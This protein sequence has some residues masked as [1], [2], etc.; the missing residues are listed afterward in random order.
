MTDDVIVV[1]GGLAGL[2]A[3]RRL[4]ERGADVTVLERRETVGGRVRSRHRDGFTLDRGFQVL[5]TGYPAVKRELDLDALDL[6]RF[7]PGAIIARPSERS[8]LS[9][10]LRDP[11]AAVESFF[12][13]EIP[14][15]DK[16]R[17]LLL[18]RELRSRDPASIFE[19]RDTDIRTYLQE[20][21]FS[22]AYANN[23]VA[24]FYGGITLDRSLSTSKRVFEYTFAVLSKGHTAV[25]ADGMGAITAQLADRAAAAG[26]TIETDTRVTGVDPTD[27]GTVE[28]TTTEGGR[29]AEAAIVATDPR[30]AAELTGVDGIPIDG[31]ASVTQ[32]YSLPAGAGP[33]TDRRILLNAKGGVASEDDAAAGREIPGV[34]TPNAMVPLTEVAPEYAPGDRELLCATFLG[35]RPVEVGEEELFERAQRTLESWYPERTFGGLEH[36]WTE[37]I[38]FGQFRQPPGIH[39]TLPDVR[40]PDGSVYLA[41]E[42]T[43]WSSIQGAMESGRVATKAVLAD[44]IGSS[45]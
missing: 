32:Y 36:V 9:D 4:A 14:L 45:Q 10:P 23:F 24:P 30:A 6:R 38:Q 35:E 2:V 31:R 40:D 3:A 17:T 41:G 12:N 22:D 25:P 18:R 34:D 7:K 21:G 5:F 37:R 15:S 28:I 43:H 20:W 8:V 39:E 19:G 44:G 27:D 11:T 26:A 42:Y 13:H 33:G 29:R 16:L 1:G